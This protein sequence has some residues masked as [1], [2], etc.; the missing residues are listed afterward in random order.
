[1]GDHD[2]YGTGMRGGATAPGDESGGEPDYELIYE[3]EYSPRRFRIGE[4][5]EMTGMTP[6]R[7]R[8]YEKEGLFGGAREENGYRWFTA[9]DAFRANAFRMLL[10]YGFSVD[11]AIEMIDS[12]Q[13]CD[14]FRRSLVDLHKDL[15][16]QAE[17]VRYRMESVERALDLLDTPDPANLPEGSGFEVVDMEDWLYV[18]ASH[19]P[20]FSVSKENAQVLA[21]FYEMLFATYCIRILPMADLLG[22]GPVVSPNYAN[23]FRASEGWRIHPDDMPHVKRL[24]LGKCL[25]TRRVLTRAESLHRESYAPVFA[26][27]EAHGYRVRGDALLIPAFLNLDGRGSDVETLYLPIS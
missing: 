19:G 8:F 12:R 20:D 9:H 21:H 2:D 15:R 4:F 13:C 27:L 3:R 1:M 5:A 26:Y 17:L 14:E 11:Q 22:S 25:L 6:S 7:V 18:E 24:V 23:G 16:R 10:K